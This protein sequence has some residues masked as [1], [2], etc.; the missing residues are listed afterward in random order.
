MFR[1]GASLLKVGVILMALAL[2]LVICAV[3][4]GVALRGE[5][6][7]AAEVARKL[8][9]ERLLAKGLRRSP[10]ETPPGGDEAA[11]R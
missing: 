10:R 7:R 11:S 3:V 4:V 1:G 8:L 9:G 2:A 6:G 5:A